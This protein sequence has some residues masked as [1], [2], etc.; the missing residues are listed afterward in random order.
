VREQF[1]T[2]RSIISN[3]LEQDLFM[4]G[5]PGSFLDVTMLPT[6][7]DICHDF[8]ELVTPSLSS[9][10]TTATT[11][12]SGMSPNRTNCPDELMPLAV[13]EPWSEAIKPLLEEP[14]T[15]KISQDTGNVTL[16][17]KIGERPEGDNKPKRMRRSRNQN[18]SKPVLQE[19]SLEELSRLI[20]QAAS[21]EEK[22]MLRRKRRALRN[23]LSAYVPLSKLFHEMDYIPCE[24]PTDIRHSSA[25]RQRRVAY[26]TKLEWKVKGLESENANLRSV[27]CT[28]AGQRY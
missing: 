5:F 9:S 6:T 19:F 17:P 1:L 27:L 2:A 8:S 3:P 23:K 15:I 20:E 21:E 12:I 18:T 24:F 14:S 10:I 11:S 25:F 4:L 22:Q 28:L 16:R 26:I 7:S 13:G